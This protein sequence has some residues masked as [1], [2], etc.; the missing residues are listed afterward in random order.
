MTSEVT[1]SSMSDAVQS[2]ASLPKQR[3]AICT[4][5]VCAICVL[6][7]LGIM[8]EWD[9]ESSEALTK[10]GYYTGFEVRDGA[11]WGLFTSAF[12]H[13][14]VLHLLFNI[15]WLYRLG[16]RLEQAIGS[17]WWLGFFSGANV[18]TSA[19]QLAMTG[20]TGYG[21]S[22][23]GYALFGFMWMTRRRFTVFAEVLDPRTIALFLI[24]LVG[25]IF[26]TYA[27]A[28]NVG[29]AAHISGL[30]FGIALGAS[31]CEPR[32]RK[33]LMIAVAFWLLRRWWDCFGL[34]GPLNGQVGRLF[35]HMTK[36]SLPKLR[37]GTKEA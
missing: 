1:E 4:W 27:Q 18:I 16:S 2:P 29:N 3:L 25:C 37:I 11:L 13:L 9:G 19:V 20:D 5:I 26:L 23:I 33:S 14:D 8:I 24:W 10:W 35:A 36:A 28:V 34:H 30:L 22:G 12:V 17:L 31:I 6:I 32:H 15:Y 7:F 21:A